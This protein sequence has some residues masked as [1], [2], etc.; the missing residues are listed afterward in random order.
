M[1]GVRDRRSHLAPWENSAA[2][3]AF[4]FPDT[5]R[6]RGPRPQRTACT[7]PRR[8]EIC[9]HRGKSEDIGGAAGR[10]RAGREHGATTPTPTPTTPTDGRAPPPRSTLSGTRSALRSE[11]SSPEAVQRP[12]ATPV[13]LRKNSDEWLSRAISS[14]FPL[15]EQCSSPGGSRARC[16]RPPPRRRRSSTACAPMCGLNA[17]LAAQLCASASRIVHWTT[18]AMYAPRSDS[19]TRG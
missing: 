14:P 17:F 16:R 19:N 15:R 4:F 6:I 12:D 2:A 5:R 10:G 1:M 7:V 13:D 8:R 9:G 11:R 18:L 3:V